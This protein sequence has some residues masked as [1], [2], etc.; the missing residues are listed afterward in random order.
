MK[1]HELDTA[2]IDQEDE[3]DE[4]DQLCLVWCR[5]HKKHEWHYIPRDA[6]Y[7]GEILKTDKKPV[8]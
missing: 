6:M 8:F 7:S 2:E 4:Y 1:N 3:I 5:K